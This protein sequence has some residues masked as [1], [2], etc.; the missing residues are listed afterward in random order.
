DVVEADGA[1]R[2]RRERQ[3]RTLGE[4]SCPPVPAPVSKTDTV[5]AVCRGVRCGPVGDRHAHVDRLVA[6]EIRRSGRRSGVDNAAPG[7]AHP[8]DF[9][10]WYRLTTARNGG[11]DDNHYTEHSHDAR[12]LAHP[13]LRPTHR[14][15]ITLSIGHTAG[16]SLRSEC[17]APHSV[18]IGR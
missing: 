14:P 18:A 11:D 17:A 6:P 1:V 5:V 9:G 12:A 13:R 10:A 2:A 3:R 16:D 4:L 15:A 7:D 8:A